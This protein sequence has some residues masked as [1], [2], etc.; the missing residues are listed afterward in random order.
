MDFVTPRGL[1]ALELHYLSAL[2]CELTELSPGLLRVTHRNAPHFEELQ[3]L[4]VIEPAR[5]LAPLLADTDGLPD[6]STVTFAPQPDPLPPLPV[7]GPWYAVC[8]RVLSGLALPAD[9]GRFQVRPAQAG[10]VRSAYDALAGDPYLR[11]RPDWTDERLAL[12]PF[13]ARGPGLTGYVAYAAGEPVGLVDAFE[14]GNVVKVENLWV[15]SER[16]GEGAGSAL[17][18]AAGAGRSV[19]ATVEAEDEA[20][21][22]YRARGLSPRLR[23]DVWIRLDS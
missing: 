12:A 22:F 14:D 13:R 7:G 3:G 20:V 10:P 23:Q 17:L 1:L 6:A 15:T 18:A 9:H 16:R 2:G 4:Y 8:R 19:V 21:G 5:W 11:W